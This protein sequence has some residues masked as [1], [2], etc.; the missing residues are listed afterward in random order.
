M[1]KNGLLL[2]SFLFLLAGTAH[3]FWL[4]PQAFI[5]S[6]GEEIN[7]RFRVGEQFTGENWSG[8]RERIQQLQLFYAEV[9]DDLSEQVSEHKGDSLQFTFYEEGTAL[10]CF[11]STN[12]F[13]ELDAEKFRQYLEE[14]GL[15]NALQY[16][17]EHQET[18][19]AGREY[20][21]RSVKTLLQVGHVT[22][23][24]YQKRTSLPLDL[25]P[26]SHPYR[27]TK[28]DTMALQIF[29]RN[30][31]ASNLKVRVWKKLTGKLT[32][33]ELVSDSTGTVRFAVQPEGEW[34]VSCVQMIRLPDDPKAQWQSYWGSITW[35]YTGKAVRSATSR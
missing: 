14:D 11:Q 7:I 8:N 21:Q 28:P 6:R 23:N 19:S 34:M 30:E 32:T 1:K 12:S 27:I 20:Y 3:E 16:R 5:V 15:T 4:E 26:M 9:T 31:P 29:F 25:V 35:G 17:Q 18:D 22:T 10:V 24:V 13:L 33:T 2:L